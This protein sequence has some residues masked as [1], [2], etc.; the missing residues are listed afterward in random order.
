[1]KMTKLL[2]LGCA[3]ALLA[4]P[5]ASCGNKDKDK[6]GSSGSQENKTLNIAVFEGGYGKTVW[7]QVVAAFEAK[8]P[9][10]KVNITSNPKLGDIIRPNLVSGKNVPDFVYLA[11]TNESGILQSLI[12]DNGLTDLSDVFTAELKAK[13]LDG[14]LQGPTVTPYSDGKIYSAPLFYNAMGLWYNKKLFADNGWTVPTTWD[15]F[16]ALGDKAKEKGIA[17]FTY[18]A[19]N[20]PSYNESVLF[21]AIASAGGADAL[22]NCFNYVEGAWKS[23]AVKKVF[24]VYNRIATGGYL[25]K[26]TVALNHTQ[27]Q[28][29]FINNKALFIP[30]GSWLE[31]EMKDSQKAE[32]FE[33]GFAALP[34]FGGDKYVWTGIEEMYIPKKAANPDLA[35]KFM[36]FLYEDESIKLFAEHAK[37]IPPVKGAVEILKPFVDQ[38]AYDSFKVMENGYKSVTGG[39]AP[40]EQT[41][42]NIKN[43]L[44]DNINSL[45]NGDITVD[46]WITELENAATELRKIKK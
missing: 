3:T 18:Q 42:I 1:M 12:A 26:G 24:D 35:K 34:G 23:D 15:E 20:A 8:N 5:L 29:E 10:V 31:G 11:A 9:G 19:A 6:E 13:M 44:F 2:A 40:T 14:S 28:T 21:P 41:E 32:G 33:Y 43:V 27:A 22:Q 39:F 36:A 25:L 4:L 16:F 7:E 46:K 17:L 45:M 38:S 37:G 30:C